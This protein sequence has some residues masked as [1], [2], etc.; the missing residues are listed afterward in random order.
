MFLLI[1]QTEAFCCYCC[2]FAR[3]RKIP[4]FCAIVVV[5]FALCQ[6]SCKIHMIELTTKK[7]RDSKPKNKFFRV[8]L[9]SIATLKG[10]FKYVFLASSYASFMFQN[11]FLKGSVA[12]SLLYDK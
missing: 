7:I 6:V 12:T 2:C 1:F 4:R 11:L 9:I 5:V 3:K 8:C 10:T